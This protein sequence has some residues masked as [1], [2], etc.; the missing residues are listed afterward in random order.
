[1]IDRSWETWET[2]KAKEKAGLYKNVDK[3]KEARNNQAQND[4]SD[5]EQ[6]LWNQQRNKDLIEVLEYWENG[7]V[8]TVGGRTRRPRLP[9]RPAA[10]QVASRS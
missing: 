7:H 4:Y 5:R 3:L 10:D 8:V 2:L 6:L 9:V 1:M